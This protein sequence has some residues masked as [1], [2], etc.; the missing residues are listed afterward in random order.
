MRPNAKPTHGAARVLPLGHGERRRQYRAPRMK[1]ADD[2]AVAAQA[3]VSFV[4]R[5]AVEPLA[6][7]DP[8]APDAYIDLS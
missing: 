2:V 3:L 6:A 8:A 5:L 4:E 7:N 1:A